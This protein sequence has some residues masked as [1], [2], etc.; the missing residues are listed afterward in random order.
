[1]ANYQICDFCGELSEKTSKNMCKSCEDM[2]HKLRDIVVA[3]PDT[4]VLDLSNQTG[5]SVSRILSFANR[6]YF[7]MKAGTIEVN[8]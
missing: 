3:Y 8:E 7:V 1:M 4:M 6:G 2:Y 5:I